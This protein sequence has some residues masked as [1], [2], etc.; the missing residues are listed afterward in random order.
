MTPD[1]LPMYIYTP[2][3]QFELNKRTYILGDRMF[4]HQDSQRY[5]WCD[6]VFRENSNFKDGTNNGG[7][8]Y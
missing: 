7:R 1:A 5:Y 2:H 3:S 8:S 4:K 6:V